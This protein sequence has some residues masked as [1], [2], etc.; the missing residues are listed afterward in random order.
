MPAILQFSIK[1]A[2]FTKIY[3][4]WF[5][6]RLWTLMKNYLN[7]SGWTLK[8]IDRKLFL[9]ICLDFK[10]K[11]LSITSISSLPLAIITLANLIVAFIWN[12]CKEFFVD[13]D[14]RRVSDHASYPLDINLLFQELSRHLGILVMLLFK[15][16]LLFVICRGQSTCRKCSG[17]I[18]KSVKEFTNVNPS[19]D[20]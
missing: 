4:N 19:K 20:V 5:V 7:G 9:I 13:I 8:I 12:R 2:F 16:F 11:R 18:S 10:I 14:K 6:L 1:L 3:S 15:C 17:M